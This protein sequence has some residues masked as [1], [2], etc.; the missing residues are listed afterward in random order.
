MPKV[1]SD[2]AKPYLYPD[3]D[4]KLMACTAVPVPMRLCFDIF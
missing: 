2:E 4:A 1:S 3:E